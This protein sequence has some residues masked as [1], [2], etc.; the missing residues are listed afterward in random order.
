MPNAMFFN[1]EREG[2]QTGLAIHAATGDDIAQA[3]QP[4]QRRLRASV[5]AECR[6]ALSS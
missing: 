3:G 2:V 6:D 1:W 5:A 4:R